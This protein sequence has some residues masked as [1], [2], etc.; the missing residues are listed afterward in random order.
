[1][2]LT[3]PKYVPWWLAGECDFN[4]VVTEAGRRATHRAGL[5]NWRSSHVLSTVLSIGNFNCELFLL[6]PWPPGQRVLK[7]CTGPGAQLATDETIARAPSASVVPVSTL[8][9]VRSSVITNEKLTTT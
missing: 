7:P 6:C 9:V 2:L 4:A 5:R 1:M 3:S 8:C